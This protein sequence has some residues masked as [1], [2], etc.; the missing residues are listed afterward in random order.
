MFAVSE[1]NR[2]QEI[3]RNF[4]LKITNQNLYKL[5][6]SYQPGS[7]DLIISEA[8]IE[9]LKDP[10][11]FLNNCHTLLKE[12]G[13][14]LISTPNIATLLKRVRFL[15]GKSPNWP[16]EE[17][18]AAG[19]NFTGHWREYTLYELAKMCELSGFQILT[20]SNKNLLTKFKGLRDWKK[21][22]RATVAAIS[23]LLPGTREMV[24]VLAKK[25]KISKN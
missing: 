21:N 5:T 15:L 22:L 25:A 20:M 18:F 24:Y 4:N 16:V 17:F 7:I 10:K 3:W 11:K 2:L 9:H 8:V 6:E 1:I 12:G 14:L 23:G 19:E 13:I